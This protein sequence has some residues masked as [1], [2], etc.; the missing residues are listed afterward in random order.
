MEA[1]VPEVEALLAASREI[2]A[3]AGEALGAIESSKAAGDFL[4]HLDHAD[5]LLALVVG[6]GDVGIEQEGEDAIVIVLQAVEEVGG[7]G[8]FG[9]AM[10]R[11]ATRMLE[12][13]LP[14]DALVL[15]MSL[16]ESLSE[17]GAI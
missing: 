4:F 10:P 11:L 15:G 6:E 9:A 7:L 2:A 17:K 13:S 5:V 1:S 3:N 14:N 8:L 12:A 16:I